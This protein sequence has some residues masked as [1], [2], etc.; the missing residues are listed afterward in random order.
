MWEG[1]GVNSGGLSR[2]VMQEAVDGGSQLFRGVCAHVVDAGNL[3]VLGGLFVAGGEDED[4]NIRKAAAEFEYELG[5]ANSRDVT[6]G[7]DESQN[8]GEIFG[9]NHAESVSG[10]A[11]ADDIGGCTL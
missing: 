9:F 11:D 2:A 5:A 6:A 10:T 1:C 7:D 3:R 8:A 4:R